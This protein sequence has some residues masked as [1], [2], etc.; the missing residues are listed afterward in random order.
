MV[1]NPD[2]GTFGWEGPAQLTPW[3]D[4]TYS[5]RPPQG[6]MFPGLLNSLADTSQDF[7]AGAD[8]FIPSLLDAPQTILAKM[9][10]LEAGSASPGL[11]YRAATGVTTPG[12]VHSLAGLHA[13]NT[14]R[15]VYEDAV[16]MKKSG[17]S[18]KEI[19]EETGM[20][21]LPSKPE[22]PLPISVPVR[23]YSD[24][25]SFI[26]PRVS[27]FMDIPVEDL[28]KTMPT[29]R[30]LQVG[31]G[32]TRQFPLV[33]IL[34]HPQMY[35]EYPHL[36]YM[37]VNIVRGLDPGYRG[38]YS[39]NQS[40]PGYGDIHLFPESLDITNKKGPR[41][42]MHSSLLHELTHAV[43]DT[44]GLVGG[45]SDVA[46]EGLLGAAKKI[47]VK[48]SRE[49]NSQLRNPAFKKTLAEYTQKHG[50]ILS[51][52]AA[53]NIR[54]LERLMKKENIRPRELTGLGDW[55]MFE[56][57]RTIGHPPNLKR[58]TLA[59]NEYLRSA[60]AAMKEKALGEF[61][62][63]YGRKKFKLLENILS[64]ASDRDIK[65]SLRRWDYYANKN[66][67]VKQ[68]KFNLETE[69]M[70]VQDHLSALGELRPFDVYAA[71]VGE[72]AARAVQNRRGMRSSKE[73]R[74]SPFLEDWNMRTQLGGH[75][76][77]DMQDPRQLEG[78][79]GDYRRWSV[80]GY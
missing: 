78:L 18:Q 12:T 43:Q 80:R 63:R 25:S 77:T 54:Y 10:Q 16:N 56:L 75:H 29:Q 17:A 45:T 13:K 41:G 51:W 32:I 34:D 9:A 73:M 72:R 21:D 27:D 39:P 65:N 30:K 52:Y 55:D 42:A 58:K 38:S 66:R 26:T 2:T 74:E 15:S 36:R 79:L 20:F 57:A 35:D 71:N 11:G 47:D 64:T 14:P 1:F 23:E 6:G 24:A 44:E 59:R 40:H 70:D 31:E 50:D 19:L 60:A 4:R 5:Q 3:S 33:D 68:R 53:D 46:A 22:L 49:I 61:K 69:K 62:S 37:P 28:I 8:R 7:Q 48:R 76:I 67:G